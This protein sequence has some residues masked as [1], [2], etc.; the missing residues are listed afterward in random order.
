MG[1]STSNCNDLPYNNGL[2]T[3]ELQNGK[4]HGC[5]KLLW[6]SVTIAPRR[7]KS[8]TTPFIMYQYQYVGGFLNGVFDGNG[9]YTVY[10][11][12]L[13]TPKRRKVFY[14]V[15]GYW[16]EN[17]IGTCTMVDETGSI[18]RGQYCD[19]ISEN[20]NISLNGRIHITYK[21]GVIVDCTFINNHANGIGT[22]VFN[23]NEHY[24]GSIYNDEMYDGIYC[25]GNTITTYNGGIP[26]AS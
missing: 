25:K 18:H 13:S 21:T 20:G 3:G 10:N 1:T 7:A 8:T 17:T 22:I 5:G 19:M 16:H 24:S 4:P 12:V 23:S 2:Y 26:T 11:T 15:T 14:T 6:G 9:T